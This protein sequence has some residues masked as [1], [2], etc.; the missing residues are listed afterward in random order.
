MSSILPPGGR[1]RASASSCTG[2]T[3]RAPELRAV[4]SLSLAAN[5]DGRVDHP[6]LEGAAFLAEVY[7]LV[8]HAGRYF[9]PGRRAGGSGVP[10]EVVIAS[11]SP[12]PRP[13]IMCRCWSRPSP[14]P[15]I[16]G[17][18]DGRPIRFLLDGEVLELTDIDPTRRC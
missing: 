12:T 10:G 16:A 17:A 13:I 18:D 11:A 14:T 6:L 2:S 1:R 8:F 3:H 7:E 15:P 4:L 5:A 9:R